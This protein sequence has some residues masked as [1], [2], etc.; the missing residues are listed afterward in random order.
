MLDRITPLILTFNEAPNL[1]RT[2]SKLTW[3]REVI[4]LDSGSTDATAQIAAAAP[5]ARVVTRPFT[6]LADQWTF[7]LEGAG[8]TTDWVLALDADYVLTDALIEELKGL[9]PDGVPDGYRASFRYCIQGK[10]LRSGVYPPVTVLFRRRRT[11]YEQDG[12]CQ[13]ALPA[14]PV[15]PLTGFIHHDDRKS[16]T[17]WFTSQ[18]GYMKL[19]ADKLLAAEPRSLSRVDRLR[20]LLVVAPPAMFVNCYF[21]RGGIF[22]GGAGLFY[23]LQRTA[24]ELILALYLLDRRL[25]RSD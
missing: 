18:L 25:F 20:M 5:N 4:V 7:G 23:A 16:L 9:D 10:V 8:I 6:T 24:A 2:L 14:G 22:D 15:A 13:R 11:R 1:E 17:R 3:A 12:H 19:E 21:W